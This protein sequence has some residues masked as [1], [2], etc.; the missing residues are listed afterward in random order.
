MAERDPAATAA[1]ADSPNLT[2]RQAAAYLHL[3]EKKLYE[4]ANA[5]E[6][7]AARV[8][9]KWLFP[10]ALLDQWLHEQAHGG[11]L[12]DRLLITGSDDPLLAATV[13]ALVPRLGAEAWVAYSPTGCLP[14]LGLLARRRAN[15]CALHWGGVDTSAAQ[16]GML[17]RRF[18]QHTQWTLVRLAHREQGVM[19]RRGLEIDAIET[20]AAFDYRW[21]MRQPG[22]GSRHFL[23]SAL[24]SRGF[25][26]E[27][28]SVVAETLSEREAAGL[29]ARD[30]ADCAPGTRAAAAEFGL[31]FLPLGWEALD[32]AL[33]REILFRKLFQQLLQCYGN[34]DMRQLANRLG[35]YELRPLG[36]V[37]GSD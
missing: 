6:L 19:L 1:A 23:E 35:G 32:L 37:L 10:R 14:G 15:V 5:H 18:S 24:A 13:A 9:G 16:H 20:L 4:L 34:P 36:Q 29:L 28:C 17:L 31:G 30:E 22:A 26:P 33:P 25:R 3:N 11:V 21:A 12:T 2:A 8:G 7:P 27:D